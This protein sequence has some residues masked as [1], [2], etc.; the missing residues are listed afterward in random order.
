MSNP[1]DPQ[2]TTQPK[3]IKVIHPVLVPHKIVVNKSGGSDAVRV[4]LAWPHSVLDRMI[5]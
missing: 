1:K 3:A 4:K 2:K 5:S